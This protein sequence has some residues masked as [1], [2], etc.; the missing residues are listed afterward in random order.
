MLRV[1]VCVWCVGSCVEGS[2]A[3]LGRA[4]GGPRAD[5]VTVRGHTCFR[6]P[7]SA[8]AWCRQ[9]CTRVVTRCCR[10]MV[11]VRLQEQERR[12]GYVHGDASH[13]PCNRNGSGTQRTHSYT[14]LARHTVVCARLPCDSQVQFHTLPHSASTPDAPLRPS[15]PQSRAPK[16]VG[17]E[18]SALTRIPKWSPTLVLRSLSLA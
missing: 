15:P 2:G 8:A 4:R 3:R 10:H 13:H 9:M 7:E 6:S 14:A 1:S 16:R 11:C 12:Q 18:R 17:G 5:S